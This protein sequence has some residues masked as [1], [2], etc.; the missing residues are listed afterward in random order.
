M[1]NLGISI[2]GKKRCSIK[3]EICHGERGQ[4]DFLRKALMPF[5]ENTHS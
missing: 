1:L 5:E 4:W 2:V 3:I